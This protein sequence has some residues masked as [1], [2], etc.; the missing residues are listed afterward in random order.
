MARYTHQQ[1]P[2]NPKIRA[3]VSAYL[4]VDQRKIDA[5]FCCIHS[6]LAQ[7]YDNFEIFIHHDGPLADP[8]LANKFRSL[9]PK[10]TFLDNLE[11]RGCWGFHHRHP[12][13]MIEPH[14]DW[15]LFT[16]EDNYYVPD[17]FKIMLA[18]AT[19]N[20][21]GMAF[22]NMIHSHHGWRIFHTRP[23]P[24]GIDMGAFISRM[25][26]VKATPWTDFIACADG[27]Y[28]GKIAAITNPIKAENIL[29]VHN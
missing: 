2:G 14:A 8:N 16:N 29:F 5:A 7:T 13:A 26:L 21:S 12:T 10:I 15:V 6:L 25:D 4:N 23:G 22:C 27:I 18:A 24:N 9:S 28:A 11:K 3:V 19:N 1:I 20:N 17:F